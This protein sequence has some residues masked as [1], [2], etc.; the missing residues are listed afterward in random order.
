MEFGAQTEYGR[1]RRVLMHRPSEELRRI[2]PSNRD[3]Y[4]FRDVVYWRMFQREHDAFTEALRGE[5]V[6]VIL[7][8]DLLEGRDGEIA[9]RLPNL[10]YTRDVCS[11]T[12]LG[13]L[14]LRMAYQ[15]RYPEPLLVGKAM[16][17][18]GIPIALRVAPPGTV[19]GGDFV[20]LDRETLMVGFGT[21]T[22]EVGLEMVKR[23]LLGKAVKRLLAVPLPSFRVHLDGGLMILSPDLALIHKPSLEMYPAYLYSEDGVELI[24]VEDYL[25]E[26]GIELI[27]ADD[28][29]V[30]Q[31]GTNIVGIGGGKCVSYEW[32]ERIIA[33]LE[34]RGLDVI[35]I[36]GSQLSLGGG[37]PHCMT[38]PILRDDH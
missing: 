37:G 3:A 15:A 2:T 25:R 32:N 31:F 1:L 36:P 10:V 27:Y 28:A 38:C 6:E 34:E 30:R 4:L 17:R 8:E 9:A 23:T 20:Y 35:R 14:V 11:V 5:G 33:E 16:E 13:A 7:L 12:Y 22:N 19:E 21:R 26:R 29:E 18:L 24:F